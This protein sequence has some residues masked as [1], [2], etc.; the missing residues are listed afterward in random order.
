MWR[1]PAEAPCPPIRTGCSV[2]ICAVGLVNSRV[3]NI[4]RKREDRRC[5]DGLPGCRQRG[6]DADARGG[7]GVVG[8]NNTDTGEILA[9]RAPGM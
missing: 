3:V 9:S 7:R 1:R 6:A 5:K 4:W 2:P 8:A